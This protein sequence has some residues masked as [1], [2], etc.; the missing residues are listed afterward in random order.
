MG[1]DGVA[2][3][4]SSSRRPGLP[5]PRACS[6]CRCARQRGID[7]HRLLGDAAA[8]VGF[9]CSQGCAFVQPVGQLDQQHP[10]IAG[11]RQHQLAEILRLL[12]AFGKNFQ[13]G[14]LGD[15]VDQV[16]DF[17]AELVA[18][19]LIGDQRVFDGVVQQRRHNGG[20]IQ[21]EVGEDGRHFQGMGEIGIARG[22]ELLAMGGHGIDIGL[23]EQRLVGVGV[24]SQHPLDQVGLAHQPPASPQGRRDRAT[25]GWRSS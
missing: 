15:A 20:H 12:G 6:A 23:V 19:V 3:F 4:G 11:D 17:L 2:R 25:F 14:E 1:D 24:V 8:L 21:L 5:A 16:G 9:R 7:I 18:D 10:D 13:L 22:A